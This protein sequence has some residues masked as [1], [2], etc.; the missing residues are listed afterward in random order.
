MRLGIARKRSA[1]TPEAKRSAARQRGEIHGVFN[2]G[3]VLFL[4]FFLQKKA[5]IQVQKDA[6][7]KSVMYKK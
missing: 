1:N 7:L 6:W 3:D 4:F 2:G 5:F